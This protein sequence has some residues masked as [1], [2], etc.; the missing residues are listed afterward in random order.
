MTHHI[1]PSQPSEAVRK[2]ERPTVYRAAL[3]CAIGLTVIAI[4]VFAASYT[5][6]GSQFIEAQAIH[7]DCMGDAKC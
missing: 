4:A 5:A 6:A 1:T 3:T 7:P 2:Q